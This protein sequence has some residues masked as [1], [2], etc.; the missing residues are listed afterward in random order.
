MMQNELVPSALKGA[1][2]RR[3]GG[4]VDRGTP[5]GRPRRQGSAVNIALWSAMRCGQGGARRERRRRGAGDAFEAILFGTVDVEEVLQPIAVQTVR[6]RAM[7]GHR[8]RGDEARNGDACWWPAMEE[9]CRMAR[10]RRPPRGFSR[11]GVFRS[12]SKY[13]ASSRDKFRKRKKRTLRHN[14]RS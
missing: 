12:L 4:W 5:Q 9:E 13:Y 7:V 6:R 11:G 1:A 3:R 8:V 14:R 10:A 2:F